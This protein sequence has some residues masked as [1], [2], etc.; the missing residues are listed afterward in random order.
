MKCLLSIPVINVLVS[1]GSDKSIRFWWYFTRAAFYNEL[2]AAR[3]VAKIDPSQNSMLGVL[4]EHYRP[5]ECLSYVPGETTPESSIIFSAD[6]M[7]VIK[8]WSIVTSGS[9]RTLQ[10]TLLC[11]IEGHSTGINDMWYGQGQLWTG[12]EQP[13]HLLIWFI[14][15][16]IS[17]NG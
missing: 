4:N 17:I 9:P 12:F 15:S 13:L 16:V 10:S 8:V 11:C 14:N 7:G 5:V 6:S 3:D 2:T 1:G